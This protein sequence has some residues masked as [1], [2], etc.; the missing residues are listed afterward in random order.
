MK[1][2]LALTLLAF[3]LLG[4]AVASPGHQYSRK[5]AM[6]AV[7]QNL[8]APSRQILEAYEQ[9]EGQANFVFNLIDRDGNFGLC[10]CWVIAGVQAMQQVQERQGDRDF[11]A[12][13]A[14][15]QQQVLPYTFYELDQYGKLNICKCYYVPP[16]DGKFF[17][18]VI[19]Y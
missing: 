2:S 16:E 13:R 12:A 5:K 14:H 8:A 18:D 10:G 6:D 19:P 17:L 1:T 7:D 15:V 9:Q 3:C 4:A 11:E